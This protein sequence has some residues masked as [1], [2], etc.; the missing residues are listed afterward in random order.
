MDNYEFFATF[1]FG[2][3]SGWGILLFGG[4]LIRV[5]EVCRA[6]HHKMTDDEIIDWVN[7][8]TPKHDDRY[9]QFLI[10]EEKKNNGK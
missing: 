3:I 7:K 10:D 8:T 1:I 5:A 9:I 4:F 2:I 6:R